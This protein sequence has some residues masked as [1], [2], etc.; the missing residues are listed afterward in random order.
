MEIQIL[1]RHTSMPVLWSFH[2]KRQESKRKYNRT[3][4]FLRVHEVRDLSQ[5]E[6]PAL[7]TAPK[8]LKERKRIERMLAAVQQRKAKDKY[9]VRTTVVVDAD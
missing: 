7:K 2:C 9:I 6:I 1:K 4:K 3:A 5:R 8:S